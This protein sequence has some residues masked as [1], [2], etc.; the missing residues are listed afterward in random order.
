MKLSLSVIS[1]LLGNVM[2][3]TKFDFSPA[4]ARIATG[5]QTAA[6]GGGA[7][8]AA[9][10]TSLT[11]GT[12]LGGLAGGANY[13]WSVVPAAEN[14]FLN[15]N[16]SL[17]L[18]ATYTS[19][20][21]VSGFLINYEDGSYYSNGNPT[22]FFATQPNITGTWGWPGWQDC[23]FPV[24]NAQFER[25]YCAEEYA[26]GF[27]SVGTLISTP[28]GHIL[29]IQGYSI[30]RLVDANGDG[31]ITASLPAEDISVISTDMS[32]YDI[33]Y[34]SG[35]VY[36]VGQDSVYR[37]QWDDAQG[38]I[39]GDETDLRQVLVYNI[40]SDAFDTRV[41]TFTSDGAALLLY[42]SA[43]ATEQQD[44]S[45]K[46]RIVQYSIAGLP[47]GGYDYGATYDTNAYA[48]GLRNTAALAY[49]P[50][51][52]LW[53]VDRSQ[54]SMYRNDLG[55]DLSP[56]NN[57]AD[58][59]NRIVQG[60]F[61]GYP[62]CFSEFLIPPPFG[63]GPN[64]QWV[65]GAYKSLNLSDELCSDRTQVV[66]PALSFPNNMAISGI[67]FVNHSNP[68]FQNDS[69]LLSNSNLA[70]Y[71]AFISFS[72][73]SGRSLVARFEFDTDGM[74]LSNWTRVFSYAGVWSSASD[75]SY[76]PHSLLVTAQG[77]LLISSPYTASV[78]KLTYVS[79]PPQDVQP[80]YPA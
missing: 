63:K 67:V 28:A 60:G 41:I 73:D 78:I 36:G 37:W 44:A 47:D 21:N 68:L 13:S 30:Y 51:G 48:T 33:A 27:S 35:Y 66:P 8:A 18:D 80:L 17:P 11:C 77:D 62:Y 76:T 58:E 72:G 59:L 22:E 26:T 61:Y 50:L 46:A 74:P 54:T 45:Y 7:A 32:L 6:S 38:I 42:V 15:T 9:A 16:A 79:E 20:V 71:S 75:W 1:L 56:Y 5:I 70:N 55:G 25:G 39:D 14:L 52:N 12:G 53:G 31:N 40:S 2:A 49:D 34:H 65:N 19:Y 10:P 29:Q 69:L 3:S 24:S 43:S 64:T 23:Q 57:P 4:F